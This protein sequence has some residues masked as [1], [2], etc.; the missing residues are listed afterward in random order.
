MFKFKKITKIGA[1]FVQHS[2]GLRF[3]A[4]IIRTYIIKRAVKATMQVSSAGG[5][6]RL[7]ADK[8]IR[9]DFFFTFMTN[10]HASKNT[11]N[12]E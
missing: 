10:V 1:G 9:R 8:K 4:V 12:A 2:F 7:P 5:T 6:L 11:S 3:A